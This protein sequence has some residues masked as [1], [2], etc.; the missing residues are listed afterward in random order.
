MLRKTYALTTPKSRLRERSTIMPPEVIAHE[1]WARAWTCALCT[2][3]SRWT[4]LCKFDLLANP[5]KNTRHGEYLNI[6]KGTGNAYDS[7]Q[8]MAMPRVIV[9]H[10]VNNNLMWY[11]TEAAAEVSCIACIANGTNINKIWGILHSQD[12]VEPW[13]NKCGRHSNKNKRGS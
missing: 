2:M 3:S 10:K 12:Y 6:H 9:K 5:H 13:P 7:P 11:P 8:S 1:T 4:K